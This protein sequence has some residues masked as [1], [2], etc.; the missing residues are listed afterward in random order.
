MKTISAEHVILL[1]IIETLLKKQLFNK[2]DLTQM[3]S[4]SL[5]LLASLADSS[6]S[7]TVGSAYNASRDIDLFFEGFMRAFRQKEG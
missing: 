2:E 1:A 5:N 6:D 7:E 3:R 4:F